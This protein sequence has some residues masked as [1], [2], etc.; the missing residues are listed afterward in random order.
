MLHN[1]AITFA[2]N[3][4]SGITANE[5]RCKEL[6]DA[7]VGTITALCPHIG[8][9]RAAKIAKEALAKHIPVKELILRENV[10]TEEELHII[11]NAYGMTEPGISG[12]ELL[13]QKK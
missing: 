5:E 1:G 6:M 13:T 7:S 4:V 12:K 10:L 8:Y 3:C 2:D 11:M 9:A